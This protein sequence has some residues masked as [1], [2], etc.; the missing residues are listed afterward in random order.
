M[1]TSG[2]TALEKVMCDACSADSIIRPTRR[3]TLFPWHAAPHTLRAPTTVR[4]RGSTVLYSRRIPLQEPTTRHG[5][6][7]WQCFEARKCHHGY[8]EVIS[9]ATDIKRLSTGRG[10]ESA[11]REAKARSTVEHGGAP[12]TAASR[13]PGACPKDLISEENDQLSPDERHGP[14]GESIL[15][16]D[17]RGQSSYAGD[18]CGGERGMRG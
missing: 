5:V 11:R 16:L 8:C 3:C 14:Q 1:P 13:W 4:E 17:Q 2:C 9:R 7:H 18:P 15:I 10:I 12:V 6:V